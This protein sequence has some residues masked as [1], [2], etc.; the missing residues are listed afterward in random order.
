M[1]REEKPG[2]S[3]G[4]TYYN[5]P[6]HGLIAYETFI[7]P[8]TGWATVR[9]YLPYLGKNKCK[10]QPDEYFKPGEGLKPTDIGTPTL[11]TQTPTP[12]K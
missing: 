7:L 6:E 9:R 3:E 2:I 8:N 12:E 5:H 10:V 4:V 11:W 1:K